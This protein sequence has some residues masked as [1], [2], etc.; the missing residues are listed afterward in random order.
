[1]PSFCT[2]LQGSKCGRLCQ[3]ILGRPISRDALF[4]SSR[5]CGHAQALH[6]S[7]GQPLWQTLFSEPLGQWVHYEI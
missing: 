2:S 7:A 3:A 6:S 1:M 4:S 5:N